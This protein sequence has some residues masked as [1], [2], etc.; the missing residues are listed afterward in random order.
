MKNKEDGGHYIDTIKIDDSCK[1][2]FED[3]G[4]TLDEVGERVLDS[5]DG[6]YVEAVDEFLLHDDKF[7]FWAHISENVVEIKAMFPNED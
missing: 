3:W 4:V 1:A 7:T 5:I 6:A 2:N